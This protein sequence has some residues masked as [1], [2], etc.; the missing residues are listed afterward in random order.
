MTCKRFFSFQE[1]FHRFLFFI[2]KLKLLRLT[3][4]YDTRHPENNIFLF[5]QELQEILQ[6]WAFALG[7]HLPPRHHQHPK[8][9]VFPRVHY[10]GRTWHWCSLL[11][12]FTPISFILGCWDVDVE[13]NI[14]FGW[15]IGTQL[16]YK[17]LKYS[18]FYFFNSH[19]IVI[20]DI[21]T[22]LKTFFF[23]ITF[24]TSFHISCVE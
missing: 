12:F 5:C 8:F 6:S 15:V 7:Y 22:V 23:I 4:C 16:L 14:L 19:Q 20:L 9:P 18:Q 3:T 13:T 17:H 1:R 11:M 21:S 10:F 2:N 24:D